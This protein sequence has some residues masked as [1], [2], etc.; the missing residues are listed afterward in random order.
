MRR[1]LLLL[2]FSL[3]N[4]VVVGLLSATVLQGWWAGAV[5]DQ[6]KWLSLVIAG[7]FAYG[8]VLSI[9][10][11]WH[12][13]R[14][15]VELVDQRVAPKSRAGAYLAA[16]SALSG[17]AAT[18][19]AERLRMRL[20]GQIAIVRHI[21]NTLVFFGLVGTVIGF[22][23]ALSGVSPEQ[24]ATVENVVPMVATLIDGMSIA[25]YTTLL[26]AVL[27]LWLIVNYRILASGTLE[28]FD[29]LVEA[30]ERRVGS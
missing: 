26:G 14:E 15:L 7:V 29:A 17:E 5:A 8:M 22:I 13:N 19:A 20:A 21:A 16:R 28:L 6:T 2:R 27:Y 10:K 11:I 4:L 23:I 30:G 3:F 1:H 9:A 18:L 12:T 25:L 24:A